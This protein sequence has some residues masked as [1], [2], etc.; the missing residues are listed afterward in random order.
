VNRIPIAVVSFCVGVSSICSAQSSP[1]RDA[2]ALAII[3]KSIA[4]MSGLAPVVQDTL[5][6]GNATFVNG[7]QATIKFE[8]KGA[9]KSRH[10]LAFPNQL[11]EYVMNGGEGYSVKD[12]KKTNLPLWVTQY[13]YPE[14]IPAISQMADFA[15]ANMAVS[16]V[17]LES[18]QGASAHHIRFILTPVGDGTPANIAAL[19]SEFH[20]FVDAQTY[21][22]TKTE[23]YI[24]S[25][26]AIENRSL[27]EMYYSD[28]RSVNGLMVPYRISRYISG[29]K[30]C[31]IVFSSVEMNVGIPDSDFQ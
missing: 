26:D 2:Q 15:S 7:T 25:P 1:T 22:V 28:Y 31:D 11:V 20:V 19:I 21:L 17:G 27:V 9:T 12:G 29:G 5:A 23:N 13:H 8:S 10:E 4:A 24:F 3:A 14:H 6:Q 16:Y 18:V 30:T